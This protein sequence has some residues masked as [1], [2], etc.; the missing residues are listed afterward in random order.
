MKINFLSFFIV[1][2]LFGGGNHFF[3]Q[4]VQMRAISMSSKNLDTTGNEEVWSVPEN[5]DIPISIN[6]FDKT[7]KISS[8]K[9]IILKITDYF[10]TGE[11]YQNLILGTKCVDNKG[12]LYRINLVR[13]DKNTKL[14]FTFDNKSIVYDVVL[15]E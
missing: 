7:V 14:Y 5:V 8:N 3:A 10:S 15:M 13:E 6:T 1:L 11:E 9:E 12:N 2:L 4:A